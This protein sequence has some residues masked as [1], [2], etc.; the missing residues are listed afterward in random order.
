MAK[1]LFK[2]LPIIEYEGKLARNLMVSTKIVKDAFNEPNAFFRYTINDNESPEEVAF[3]FYGSIFFTW[4]VL[5]SNDILDVY[6]EWPK[7]YR[8]M[9]DFYVQKYGSVP[10]A[11][12]QILHYKNSKYNFTINPDTYTRFANTDFVDATIQVDREGW[13]PVTAFDYHEERNDNLRN[14][15][16]IDPS[17]LDQI[18]EESERL[19]NE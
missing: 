4:L 3:I 17:F 8:Q 19:F 6:N 14:I 7:T 9:T 13:Y 16:L 1:G 15:K 11:K 5:Y 12:E 2:N 10:E 18:Q